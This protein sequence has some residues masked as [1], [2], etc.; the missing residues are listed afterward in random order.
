MKMFGGVKTQETVCRRRTDAEIKLLQ[1]KAG[2]YVPGYGY[3]YGG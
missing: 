1:D 2:T 3:G